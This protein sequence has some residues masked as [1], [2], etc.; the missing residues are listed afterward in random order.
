MSALSVVDPIHG[1]TLDARPSNYLVNHVSWPLISESLNWYNLVLVRNPKGFPQNPDDGTRIYS[2]TSDSV[3]LG[4]TEVTNGSITATG[5][6][7]LSLGAASG[8]TA[9]NV[10]AISTGTSLGKNATVS[11]DSSGTATIVNGGAGYKVGDL[12]RIP[13]N[14]TG[15]GGRDNTTELGVKNGFHVYD[16]GNA[17]ALT[18]NPGYGITGTSLSAPKYYYSLFATYSEALALPST[19]DLTPNTKWKKL[20]EA[21]SFAVTTNATKSTKNTLI[22]LLPKFYSNA[23]GGTY[24]KDLD[25][26]L[27]LFAFHLDTYLA[28]SNS[29]FTMSELVTADE[30]E[31]KSFIRQFGG[32]LS[33][34]TDTRRAR[35]LLRNLLRAYSYS[36]SITGIL[37]YLEAYSGY[38]L[39]ETKSKNLLLDYNSSSFADSTGA[40]YPDPDY[41][42]YPGYSLYPPYFYTTGETS[43]IFSSGY[44]ELSSLSTSSIDTFSNYLA[45]LSY[46]SAGTALYNYTLAG[47]NS[48]SVSKTY[49][50]NGD[51]VT[52]STVTVTTTSS[53]SRLR[54]GVKLMVVSGTGVLDTGTVVTSV[55][56]DTQFTI[57]KAPTTT[58]SSATLAVSTNLTSKALMVRPYG[59]VAAN[60][61]YYYGMRK[62]RLANTHV[63]GLKSNVYV[64]DGGTSTSTSTTVILQDKLANVTPGATIVSYNNN[65][66]HAVVGYTVVGVS[67]DTSSRLNVKLN[68]SATWQNDIAI[69]FS[70]TGKAVLQSVKP[71]VVKVGDYIT[72]SASAPA[73][74]PPGTKVDALYDM[75][76]AAQ[77]SQTGYM[78]RLSKPLVGTVAAN[79]DLYFSKSINS[80]N[81]GAADCIPVTPNTPYAFCMNFNANGGTTK[82][83]EVSLTWFDSTGAIT[84]TAVSGTQTAPTSSSPIAQTNFATKWY[85]TMVTGVSPSTAAY[86]QPSFKITNAASVSGSSPVFYYVDGAY[87]SAPI[88]VLSTSLTSNVAQIKTTQ[89]HNFK[90]GNKIAV[91]IS[92][93]SVYNTSSA[94]ITLVSQNARTGNYLLEYAATSATNYVEAFPTDGYVASIPMVDVTLSTNNALRLTQFEDAKT[95]TIN[96]TANRVNLCSNPSFEVNTTGWTASNGSVAISSINY[97][98]KF[99][100]SCAKIDYATGAIA[101]SSV[102][103]SSTSATV[104]N[105][106]V[107]AGKYY[108]FSGYMFVSSGTSSDGSGKYQIKV[109][110]YNSSNSLISGSTITSDEVTIATP[111]TTWTRLTLSDLDPTTNASSGKNCVAPAG[112]VYAKLY[113]VK[114]NFTT[115]DSVTYLDGVLVEESQTVNPYFDGGFDGYNHDSYRDSV[116]ES[117]AYLSPSHLYNNRLSNQGNIETRLTD[118]IYYG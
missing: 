40:W 39:T 15:L 104:P 1:V 16:I 29:V 77:T 108:A 5:A 24:N 60:V 85:P 101:G 47:C 28:Q 36:G 93:G 26:F 30:K 88:K 7:A 13:S 97:A 35:I 95:T 75:Y 38:K 61:N 57:N 46:D 80:G 2:T 81:P 105:I 11:L 111:S 55:V 37:N 4:V 98:H 62:G 22:S 100:S 99:T 19:E 54:P 63:S 72:T 114:T 48:T 3:I 109:E 73:S 49:T 110:W 69:E 115:A 9:T 87:L 44:M 56:N 107:T 83:T 8:K 76:T 71:F 52:N 45:P 34:T 27:S 84:G 103:F 65:H 25:D 70:S 53:T 10:S 74:I 82:D 51:T 106:K 67:Y 64:S 112:A 41:A 92:D 21:S 113:F 86:C 50:V 18:K 58:L 20:G 23:Y 59:G 78:M 118:M 32:D 14:T 91:Y 12:I 43:N 102:Y 79:T 6:H 31:L 33:N 42:S 68:A 117:T 96:V 66:A 94:A 90:V 116:W 17:T 89:P